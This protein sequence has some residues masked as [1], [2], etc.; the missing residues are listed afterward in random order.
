MIYCKASLLD[1]VGFFHQTHTASRVIWLQNKQVG[2]VSWLWWRQYSEG[3]LRFNWH[4]TIYWTKWWEHWDSVRHILGTGPF[5]VH[6]DTTYRIVQIRSACSNRRIPLYSGSL[7]ASF[8]SEMCHNP[9]DMDGFHVSDANGFCTN[10][11]KK[12][13]IQIL[14]HDLFTK[15]HVF[16]EF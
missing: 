16:R 12:C 14:I 5:C 2:Q 10:F 9:G 3:E 15:V 7:Q 4:N 11:L 8:S 6:W 1:Q 13:A